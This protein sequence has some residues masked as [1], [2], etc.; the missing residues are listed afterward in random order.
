M[1]AKFMGKLRKI[2]PPINKFAKNRYSFER[3]KTLVQIFYYILLAFALMTIIRLGAVEPGRTG[4]F[5]IWPV[6]WAGSIPYLEIREYIYVAFVVT[7]FIGSIFWHRRLG[8]LIFFLG[9]L[10]YHAL[11]SS[12]GT[13]N[14]FL[15]PWLYGSFLFLFLPDPDSRGIAVKQKFLLVFWGFQAL[16]LLTYSM[17]GAYK[18]VGAIYQLLIGQISAFHPPA[19]ALQVIRQTTNFATKPPLAG[20]IVKN[21]LISWPMY[22]GAVFVE[23]F[24]F[25]AAIRPSLQRFWGFSL[26][27]LHT[28]AILFMGIPFWEHT[29]LLSIL[30]LNSPFS[31]G[32]ITI[33]EFVGELPLLGSLSRS[34]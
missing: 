24:A 6:S 5:P 19:F 9:F 13:P 32:N 1:V 16:F 18:L 28:G 7:S 34:K 30:F 17:G 31:N 15:F 10:Q 22:V 11:E 3:A 23:L 29:V 21:T 26:I 14:F 2:I 12:F 4:F 8:R 25:W 20:F 33:R 27:F